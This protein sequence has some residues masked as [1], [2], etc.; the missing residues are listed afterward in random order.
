[1]RHTHAIDEQQSL[2]MARLAEAKHSA[3]QY[4]LLSQ[5]VARLADT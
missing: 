5:V 2:G 4:P 1:M 3:V